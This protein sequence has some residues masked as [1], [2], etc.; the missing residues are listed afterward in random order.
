MATF[1]RESGKVVWRGDAVVRQID[2]AT[3]RAAQRTVL[4]MKASAQQR[5]RVR[6]G[7]MRAGVEGEVRNV[8]GGRLT[9][10]L[11]DRVL[12]SIY[13]ADE[14]LEPSFR[15]ESARFAKRLAAEM[16]RMR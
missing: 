1:G 10:T 14:F 7:R 2:Q 4:A 9:M 13:Y 12:Y 11:S 8:A 16:A 15:E 3:L 5:A 6:T